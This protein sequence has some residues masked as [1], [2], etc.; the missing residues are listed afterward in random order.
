LCCPAWSWCCSGILFPRLLASRS[1]CLSPLTF[2]NGVRDILY[3]R[4]WFTLCDE[5][6]YLCKRSRW[7]S[8]T[9]RG[10]MSQISRCCRLRLRGSMILGLEP[11]LIGLEVDGCLKLSDTGYKSKFEGKRCQKMSP[12]VIVATSAYGQVCGL[13]GSLCRPQD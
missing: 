10:R 13:L 7:R 9:Y 2:Q 12:C 5:S 3:T 6:T 8:I 11:G 4:Y 1:L